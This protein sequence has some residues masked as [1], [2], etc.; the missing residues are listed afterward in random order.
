[1]MGIQDHLEIGRINPMSLSQPSWTCY[2]NEIQ[3][4]CIFLKL[5]RLKFRLLV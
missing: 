3:I 1:M 4:R 2:I 5:E